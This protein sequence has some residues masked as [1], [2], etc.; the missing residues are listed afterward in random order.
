MSYLGP[1]LPDVECTA[2]LIAAGDETTPAQWNL[3][4]EVDAQTPSWLLSVWDPNHQPLSALEWELP[5]GTVLDLGTWEQF[6]AHQEQISPTLVTM[7]Q[8]MAPKYADLLEPGTHR[9]SLASEGD[10]AP[11]W[12]WT[13]QLDVQEELPYRL[14]LDLIAVGAQFVDAQAFEED[15][16]MRAALVYAQEQFALAGIDLHVRTWSVAEPSL[17]DAYGELSNVS[18]ARELLG[19]LPN[20]EEDD[21]L[22]QLSVPVALID[23]FSIESGLLGFA[24]ALPGPVALHGQEGAGVVASVALLESY[25]GPEQVGMML[26]HELGHYLGL[27]HTSSWPNFGPDPLDDTPECPQDV[28]QTNSYDCED[29]YNVMFPLLSMSED[30]WWSEEQVE[31]MRGHPAVTQRTP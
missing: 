6:R 9:I 21:P 30:H 25:R 4:V 26:V 13:P 7:L 15:P 24:G 19:S 11:C 22:A 10:D 16:L 17:S 3:F 12:R 8:P 1:A 29:A 20:L 23:G 14:R 18:E 31:V 28:Y 5:S 2:E 27:R